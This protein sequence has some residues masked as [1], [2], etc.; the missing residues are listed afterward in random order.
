MVVR[1]GQGIVTN[2]LSG[3]CVCGGGGWRVEQSFVECSIAVGCGVV[4]GGVRLQAHRRLCA[5][6]NSKLHERQN[7]AALGRHM[8]TINWE[9]GK[10]HTHD[11]GSPV[12]GANE[13]CGGS[14]TCNSCQPLTRKRLRG[15]VHIKPNQQFH[16]LQR[17]RTHHPRSARP[18]R[19]HA[20][21][22][23]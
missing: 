2:V 14:G 4:W 21:M 11:S 6:T 17:A 16:F 20:C 18:A 13:V 3:R 23:A 8:D 22:H 5:G 9:C 15:W 12:V 7:R 19:T 1:L 10:R